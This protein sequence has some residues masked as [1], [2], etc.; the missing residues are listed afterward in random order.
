VVLAA[1]FGTRLRPLTDLRP[2]ALCPVNNVP[3]VDRAVARA[4]GFADDIAVNVHYARDQMIAHLRDVHVSVEADI[5][6]TAG[7][8]W[9]LRTW[10]DGRDVLV[11]NADAYVDGDVESLARGWDRSTPRLAVIADEQRADFGGRWRYIGMCLLPAAVAERLE[12]GGLHDQVFRDDVELHPLD[13]WFTDCGTPADYHA[14]NMHASGGAN[15][16]G[17]GA[18]VHGSIERCV[19]WPG[20]VVEANEHLRNAIR[21]DGL[22]I[23]V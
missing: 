4:R 9:N 11:V 19:V 18:R 8:L 12:R 15:V 3:L 2:K 13:V 20:S 10:I 1:G 5:L 22:T 21:A 16:V 6:G 14:A 17:D 23:A 7:A